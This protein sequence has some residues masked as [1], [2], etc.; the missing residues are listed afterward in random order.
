MRKF[1]F[2]LGVLFMFIL[3]AG[4]TGLF[5]LARH[6]NALDAE[7]KAYTRDAVAKITAD[8]DVAELWKR[9]TLQFR[10]HSSE[11]DVQ[12]FFD[13]A[14]SALGR[15][16]EYRGAE[17]QASMTV[18][19]AGESTTARYDAKVSFE[20]GDADIIVSVVKTDAS[21]QIQGF[22][23]DSTALM[24]TLVGTRS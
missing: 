18:T 17:G 9:S 13:V 21:W 11:Q 7:S 10:Q 23:I 12:K 15:M 6:G 1:I 16:R 4:G 14:R 24:R 2:G 5:M 8:W 3:G 22:H 19:P 20:K